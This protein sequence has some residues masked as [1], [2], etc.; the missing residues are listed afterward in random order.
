MIFCW[1]L[2]NAQSFAC[3][4]KPC[5][6]IIS[7]KININIHLSSITSLHHIQVIPLLSKKGIN[8]SL[9][10][11][12]AKRSIAGAALWHFKKQQKHTKTTCGHWIANPCKSCN[13]ASVVHVCTGKN[14][15]KAS[16]PPLPNFPLHCACY[17]IEASDKNE[18]NSRNSILAGT[19]VADSCT[20]KKHELVMVTEQAGVSVSD[21]RA[22]PWIRA[23]ALKDCMDRRNKF[24]KV[25]QTNRCFADRPMRSCFRCA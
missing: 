22:W 23:W 6:Y 9:G 16:W 18:H 2:L 1:F 10:A 15:T 20:A 17:L 5:I 14:Y 3:K 19:K 12:P 4:Y 24:T 21:R 13:W 25:S 11:T 8:W 7:F